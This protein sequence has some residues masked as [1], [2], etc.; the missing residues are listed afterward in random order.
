MPA[1]QQKQLGNHLKNGLSPLYIIAGNEPLTSN[2]TLAALRK[3]A[4]EH[5]IEERHSFMVERSFS[6]ETVTHLAQSNSLFASRRLIEIRIPTGKPGIDGSKVLQNLAK[7]PLLDDVVIIQLPAADREMKNS[8]WF[9][10]L[11]KTAQ[12]ILVNEVPTQQLPQWINDRLAAQKQSTAIETLHFLAQQVEGNLLAANQEIQKLGLLYPEG[13]L[14]DAQV[15]TAVLNVARHDAFQLAEAVLT[16]DINRTVLIINSLQ[17]EG[18]KAV[19]V[20]H[21]LIWS[22]KPLT[23]LKLA[24]TRGESLDPVLTRAR[25]FGPKQR[26]LKQA[27]RSL[28]LKQIEATLQKLADIDQIAKG[29]M[30]GDAWL[31][32]SRLCFGLAKLCSR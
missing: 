10:A 23:A 9:K 21:P 24:Y 13:E 1:I 5:G 2:E 19:Q 12:V 7:N 25:V 28:S 26:L 30:Q 6:W 29:V 3:A 8:A 15:K 16:G 22:F 11:D 4:K 17:D 31:E 32:I 20:M 14:S 27:V 18:E